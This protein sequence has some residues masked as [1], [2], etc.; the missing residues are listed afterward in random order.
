MPA[1]SAYGAMFDGRHCRC[2]S[3]QSLPLLFSPGDYFAINTA[4]RTDTQKAAYVRMVDEAHSAG[5]QLATAGD[6]STRTGI[7]REESSRAYRRRG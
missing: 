5:V 2:G 7:G 3:A 4:Q 1:S 6:R